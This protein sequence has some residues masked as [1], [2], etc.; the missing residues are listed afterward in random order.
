MII[1]PL[2]I[3]QSDVAAVSIQSSRSKAQTTARHRRLA[4]RRTVAALPALLPLVRLLILDD[5]DYVELRRVAR[6]S[7][8]S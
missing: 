6:E 2:N 5:A 3:F 8:I 4:A 7:A 1:T